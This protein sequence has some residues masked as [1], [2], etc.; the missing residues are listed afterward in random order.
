MQ[1]IDKRYCI[2]YRSI[3]LS[4]A[5]LAIGAGAAAPAPLLIWNN[6]QM[7]APV[8]RRAAA[9]RGA[10]AGQAGGTLLCWLASYIRIYGYSRYVHCQKI[11]G[12][13]NV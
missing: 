1:R 3:A 10:A 6:K 13:Y 5:G 8:A 11:Y 4:P 7:P 2:V 12:E 9:S